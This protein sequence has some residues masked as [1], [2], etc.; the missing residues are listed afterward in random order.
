MLAYLLLFPCLGDP[1][2]PWVA[3]NGDMLLV[4]HQEL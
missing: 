3:R 1:G 2:E 4:D